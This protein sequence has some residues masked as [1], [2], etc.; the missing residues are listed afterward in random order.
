ML[1][2]QILDCNSP[3][4][5]PCWLLTSTLPSNRF[6]GQGQKWLCERSSRASTPDGM[7]GPEYTDQRSYDFVR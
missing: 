5:A 2:G 4:K 1:I 7:L 3:T 6:V